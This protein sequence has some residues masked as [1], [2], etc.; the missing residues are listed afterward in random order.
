MTA[1]TGP[2]WWNERRYGMFLHANIATVASFS[3]IGE[4]ADWYWSH[5]GGVGKTGASS[6]LTLLAPEVHAS[7]LAEVLAYHGDRWAHVEHYDDFLPFLSLHRFDADEVL[8]LVAGAGMQFLVQTTKHHDGFCWWDAP[9]TMRTSVAHG[10]GRDLVAEVSAAC[11]RRDI[12]YGTH[13]S[14]DDWSTA[15]DAWTAAGRGAAGY[16]AEMLHPHVLDLVERYGSQL[17]WGDAGSAIQGDKR[18]RAA[19]ML[20]TEELIGRAQD[21]ADMQGFALAINDGWLIDEATFSTLRH[22][23]PADIRRTPWAL[24]RGLGPSPQYNRAERPEHMLSAGALIDLLTEVVAKGGNLLIDVGPGVDGT[25]SELQHAPLRAVGEW[26]AGHEELVS[27]STPFDRWGDAQVRY[28]TVGDEVL[29]VDLAAASE[30]VLAGIVPERYD[31]V[32]VVADDGGALHWEQHRGGVTINRIDRSPTGL[33]GVYRLVVHPAAEAIQLFD[34]RAAAPVALQPLLAGAA[35]GAVIQLGDGQYAGPV[36]VPAGVTLRGM[37]WDRTSIIGD[38]GAVHLDDDARLESIHVAGPTAHLTVAGWRAAVVGCRCDGPIEA[39]GHDVQ[40][41]SVIGTTI[42]A[43]GERTTIERCS[44]KGSFD[45][46]GIETD[47]GFGHRIVGNEL[48]DHLCGIRM[49][50]AGAS[51]VAE[52]RCASRWWAV[53]LVQCDHIEVTDNSIR[54]TMRA[55]DVDGGNGSVVSANWVV[56]GDSGTVVEFGATD[57]SV[58]DNHIERC[59]IGVLVWDAPTTRIGSNRFIDIHEEE[60]CVFGPDAD[61]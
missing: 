38:S 13:Y 19:E 34:D 52:N 45:D 15:V 49:H 14:I 39:S 35:H 46:V 4:Y 11:R 56:D 51:K 31:V 60:P 23:P 16:A 37:G 43:G 25:I 48:V 10:P 61:T 33:A 42:L 8:D 28:I 2:E 30:V 57:T 26:L 27:R 29:A 40:I 7:P 24:R 36:T 41:L 9:G 22:R 17:L 6:A 20:A 55:V 1:V 3:P 54:N 5:L 18:R 58:A 53:H 21:L 44:L 47:G 12:V 50:D 59:R 32:S